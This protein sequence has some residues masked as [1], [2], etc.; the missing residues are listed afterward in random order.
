MRQRV[1]AARVGRLA[2]TR[3]DGRPHVVPCCFTV[4]ESTAYTAVDAKP[5]SSNRLQ[6]IRN[7]ERN[8]AATLVTDHYEED[9]SN[10][11]WVRL[12]GI[13]RI[14]ASSRERDAALEL[15]ALKYVQYRDEPPPGPVIAIEIENWRAWP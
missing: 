9:W 13:A 8:A 6:R 3:P 11:W 10:L 12:D 5:K 4:E 15:L 1:S 2:T 7:L 14:L